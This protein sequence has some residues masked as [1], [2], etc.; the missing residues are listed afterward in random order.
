MGSNVVL[1]FTSSLL[2]R[3]SPAEVLFFSLQ[4]VI[5]LFQ[6]WAFLS[7]PFRSTAR[8]TQRVMNLLGCLIFSGSLFLVLWTT[9]LFQELDHGQWPIYVRMMGLAL[10][11]AVVGGVTTYI[12]ADDPRRM[13][14]PMGWFFVAAVA[15]VSII[16]A[17][18]PFLYDLNAQIQPSALFGLV[19]IAPLAF[20]TA[21]WLHAP[22]EVSV[23]ERRLAFP[24]VDALLYL[25][26]VAAG[27]ALIAS[28]LR[29]PNHLL[30]PLVGYMAISALLLARQ[31]PLLRVV[32]SPNERL[33]ERVLE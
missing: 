21:A 27:G 10:R 5:A 31:F 12:L 25:P 33:E 14:G 18:R 24:L 28:A 15:L 13:R 7:W 16:A 29:H 22:V 4:L 6:A 8:T 23:D 26:F 20:G 17:V 32:R 3:V 19:L 30:A 2:T 1:L 11:V 9:A